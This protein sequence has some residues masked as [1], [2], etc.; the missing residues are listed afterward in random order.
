MAALS[1][2]AASLLGKR[3]ALAHTLARVQARAGDVAGAR[4]AI[5]RET[6][7]DAEATLHRL[8]ASESAKQA[9]LGRDAETLA[10][11]MAAIDRFYAALTSFQPHAASSA[12]SAGAAELS[13]AMS[14]MGLGPGSMLHMYD[15]ATA[16]EFMR[17]YPELCAEADRLTGKAIKGEIDV[18]ADDF[19]R[20]TASR[21][22]TVGRYAGVV[23]LVA[24][25]D[26]II[27]QLLKEREV[28]GREREVAAAVLDRAAAE[29]EGY[30]RGKQ[31][32]VEHWMR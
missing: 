25:K 20:E 16:L 10:G 3:E 30:D 6:L 26:R 29:R 31:G 27:L 22:D 28:G 15:P 5:E 8:R 7:A 2:V 24:A 4:E 17:A 32:E 1:S 12:E 9:V 18:S 23:D 13:A 19:E 21:L 11:D 14:G